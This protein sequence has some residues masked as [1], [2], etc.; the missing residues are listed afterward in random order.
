ME[1]I[2]RIGHHHYFEKNSVI[3][4]HNT[5]INSQIELNVAFEVDKFYVPV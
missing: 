2:I 1:F 3:Y 5:I 4:S